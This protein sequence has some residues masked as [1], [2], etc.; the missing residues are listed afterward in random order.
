V[1]RGTRFNFV[2][3]LAIPRRARCCWRLPMHRAPGLAYRDLFL[4]RKTARVLR[5][6]HL[7][8]TTWWWTTWAP[9]R[10]QP[11]KR[12]E[13]ELFVKMMREHKNSGAR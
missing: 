1:W 9:R 2:K 10:D 3:R 6:L 11:V 8:P 12:P 13:F 7:L 4:K 5:F